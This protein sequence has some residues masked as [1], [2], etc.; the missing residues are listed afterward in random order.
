MFLSIYYL[1]KKIW[2]SIQIIDLVRLQFKTPKHFSRQNI[3]LTTSTS[4]FT[5][6]IFHFEN[7][8]R[9]KKFYLTKRKLFQEHCISFAENSKM[10]HDSFFLLM[11]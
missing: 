5:E 7:R 6:K 9:E 11:K 2:N 8:K 4:N 3:L 10:T 1:A